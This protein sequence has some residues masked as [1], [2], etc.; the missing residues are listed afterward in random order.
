VATSSAGVMVSLGYPDGETIPFDEHLSAVRRIANVLSIPLSADAAAGFG[1]SPEEV[2]SSI[3]GFIEAG[4]VGINI[5]DFAH[6]TKK[7]HSADRQVEKIKAIR[8]LGE[9]LKIPIVINARTDALRYAEGDEEA[10]LTEAIRR[11]VAYRDAG[12]DCVYPMGL[13]DLATISTFVNAL[14]FPVNVMIRKG[15]PPIHQLESLGVRRVSFGP[16]A[17]YSAMGLLKRV[18]KEVLDKGTYDTLT[19]GAISYDELNSLAAPKKEE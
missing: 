13:T 16:S 15:L 11:G 10:K 14:D 17:S 7:L 9:S 12:A 5:E 6:S 18:S 3:R 4:A 1:V 8:Q 2:V 19:E